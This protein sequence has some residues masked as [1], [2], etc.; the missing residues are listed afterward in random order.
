MNWRVVPYAFV[1]SVQ[2][3]QLG[4]DRDQAHHAV[5]NARELKRLLGH[6][7]EGG[8]TCLMRLLDGDGQNVS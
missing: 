4:L 1:V 2:L 7:R 3:L 8:R 6:K 5:A